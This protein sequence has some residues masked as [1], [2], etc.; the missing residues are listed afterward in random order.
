MTEPAKV[1][2]DEIDATV[3][4]P[5]SVTRLHD[6][7]VHEVSIVDRG[8]NKRRFIVVKRENAMSTE[9]RP[10]GQ[11]G[12][13]PVA[14]APPPFPPKKPGEED[15][16]EEGAEAGGEDKKPPFPPKPAAAPPGAGAGSGGL[17]QVLD[18]LGRLTS[19]VEALGGDAASIPPEALLE[20]ADIGATLNRVT[21][22][23]GAPK[24][25]APAPPA[26]P[27]P[28]GDQKAVGAGAVQQ[29]ASGAPPNPGAAATP[30]A[31]GGGDQLSKLTDALEQLVA[32]TEQT[33]ASADSGQPVD[34]APA[35][36][37]IIMTLQQLLQGQSGVAMGA[38]TGSAAFKADDAGVDSLLKMDDESLRALLEKIGAKMAKER[39]GRFKGHLDGLLGIL[40]ELAGDLSDT[41]KVAKGADA[42][43]VDPALL[44]QATAQIEQMSEV[45][46]KQAEAIN[47]LE[48][49]VDTQRAL[50]ARQATEIGLLKQL[51]PASN[52]ITVDPPRASGGA[53]KQEPGAVW[54]DDMA[55]PNTGGRRQVR[56]NVTF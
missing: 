47:A 27:P 17:K 41:N 25:A 28:A 32:V 51:A 40:N 16:P 37:A 45:V 49:A 54:R 29:D 9:L 21:E 38:G 36:Q 24:P 44:V 10:D 33:K 46:A 12:F 19:V 18:C 22:G 50:I 8:A 13:T 6:M 30:P 55:P 39:L 34:I 7:L 11:G 23:G 20:L 26:P 48:G 56:G 42:P 4:Q 3:D 35:V 2:D 43:A 53:D 52:A 15:K 5:R 31:Q 14:K 1:K